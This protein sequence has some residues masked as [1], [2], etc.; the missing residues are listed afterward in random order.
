MVA[1]NSLDHLDQLG[2]E[3]IGSEATLFNNNDGIEFH[4]EGETTNK[5]TLELAQTLQRV[6]E[7]RQQELAQKH[8]AKPGLYEQMRG[9]GDWIMYMRQDK[10]NPIQPVTRA[11][12][13]KPT[14]ATNIYS[15][16]AQRAK[17]ANEDYKF[18]NAA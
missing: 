10:L 3:Q 14:T 11:E 12:I 18:P 4:P 15:L 6:D 8:E 13:I 9:V 16:D 1:N 17:H 7:Q 2:Y 5:L